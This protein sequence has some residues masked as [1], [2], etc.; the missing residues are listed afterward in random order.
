MLKKISGKQLLPF[1]LL[2]IVVALFLPSNSTI[3]TAAQPPVGQDDGDK[4]VFTA[5]VHANAGPGGQP[6]LTL[7]LPEAAAIGEE[8]TFTLVAHDVAHDLGNLAGFQ[9]KLSYER[10]ISFVAAAPAAAVAG[11]GEIFQ[12]GPVRHQAGGAVTLGGA[13][14]PATEC[15][16]G[17]GLRLPIRPTGVGQRGVGGDVELATISFVVRAAGAYEIQVDEVLLVDFE[18]RPLGV[19]GPA[20]QSGSAEESA[21]PDLDLTGNNIIN[22][23]DALAVLD[24]W[25]YVRQKDLCLAATLERFDLNGDGC[26][27]VADIQLVLAR[28]G[29]AAD[30]GLPAPNRV[31]TVEVATYVVNSSDDRSD[32]N[33][34]DDLCDTGELANG[35]PE[36][37]LRA[38]IQQANARPGADTIHFD[39]RNNNGSCPDKIVISPDPQQPIT[40]EDNSAGMTIDG[41]TQCGA[42]AN[43]Q[44]VNGNAD[45]RIEIQGNKITLLSYALLINSANNVVRGIAAYDW[46][47]Q[48]QLTGGGAHHNHIE[49]NFLGTDGANTHLSGHVGEGEGI[50]VQWGASYNTIGG[51]SADARNIISGN[52]QDGV[53]IEGISADYNEVIGNYVGLKQNGLTALRNAADGVDVA[54][55]AAHNV[56]GGLDH[57][58]K[59]N[60]ISGNGRDGIEISHGVT[61]RHNHFMGNFVGLNAAGTAPIR[62]GQNGV[63]FEDEVNLNHVFRNVIVDNGA[64]GVRFYTVYENHVYANFIGAYPPGINVNT[65]VPHPYNI[66]IEDLIPSPNGQ[67]VNPSKPLGQ[68]GVFMLGGSHLNVVHHNVIAF[69]PEYGIYLSAEAG[70]LED[71][72][73]WTCSTHNNTFSKNRIFDNEHKGIRLKNGNCDGQNYTPNHGL[74]GPEINTATTTSITGTACSACKVEIFIADKNAVNDPGGDNHGEGRLFVGEVTAGGNGNFTVSVSGVAEDQLVTATATNSAGDTSEFGRNKLVQPPPPGEEGFEIY[75]PF[76]VRD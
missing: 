3:K 28:W 25:L 55:G 22:E 7:A 65:V 32:N 8:V 49:G 29:E 39:I 50:R 56:V 6:R 20:V 60:V 54:E 42:S 27:D 21:E 34:N 37:T 13:T 2:L 1:C 41:Y 51:I 9:V 40:V 31:E 24:A 46:H 11:D 23:S 16:A 36:C 53:N 66:A 75:L 76:V 72:F 44:A 73:N 15:A 43:T 5:T 12:L 52:I 14:C 57:P 59:R 26:I 10:G 18:G 48:I 69:H 62:N 61:A 74:A 64:N 63:T 47:R 58:R 17:A 68:S 71:V 38:A 33:L 45:V 70:Y 4:A 67:V 30:P 35:Q 19:T